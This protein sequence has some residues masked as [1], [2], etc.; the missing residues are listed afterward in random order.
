MT[1]AI[2]FLGDVLVFFACTAC[3]AAFVYLAS[4]IAGL[5]LLLGGALWKLAFSQTFA[6]RRGDKRRQLR[7]VGWKRSHVGCG[8]D[9]SKEKA[10]KRFIADFVGLCAI[11]GFVYILVAAIVFDLWHPWMTDTEKTVYG[12]RALTFQTVKYSEAR[13]PREINSQRPWPADFL[14]ARSKDADGTIS[15]RLLAGGDEVS[16]MSA[17]AK[18]QKRRQ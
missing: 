13:P 10:M 6:T 1:A 5:F 15:S 8:Q 11:L 18:Q 14:A 3:V 16:A 2:R 17:Q 12:A 4:C 7:G 9:D